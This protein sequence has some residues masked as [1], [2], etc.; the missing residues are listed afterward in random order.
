MIATLLDDRPHL[1]LLPPASA[2]LDLLADRCPWSA[3]ELSA[4][5]GYPER[6]VRRRLSLLWTAGAVSMIGGAWKG[7]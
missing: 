5:L 3:S 1:A 6:A 2:V 7:A 4:V